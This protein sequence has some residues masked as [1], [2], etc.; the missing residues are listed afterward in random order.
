MLTPDEAGSY[1]AVTSF[2]LRGHTTF[3][4]NVALVNRL[5][6]QY[7]IFTVARKGPVGGAC[8]RVTPGLFTRTGDLDQ[9]VLALKE[10]G[11]KG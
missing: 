2:R 11:Q 9:L 4:Q 10:L 3:E 6:E 7:R 1:G 8:I 5:L